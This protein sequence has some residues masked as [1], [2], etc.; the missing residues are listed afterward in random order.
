M[1]TASARARAPI[2]I[3]TVGGVCDLA[4][5][6]YFRHTMNGNVSFA[7]TNAPVDVM[8]FDLEVNLI[9]GA[10]TFPGNVRWV[11][12]IPPGDV[13]AG[14]LHFFNFM[15]PQSL[16]DANDQQIDQWVGS[17]WLNT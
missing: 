2:S 15:R 14:K 6:T 17:F 12:G 3:A 7:F 10:M 11:R 9:S 8:S 13:Q 4:Q 16:R 1:T 5:S